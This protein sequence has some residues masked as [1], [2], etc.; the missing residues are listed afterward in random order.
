MPLMRMP[1][2]EYVDIAD[3]TPPEVLNR[4]RRQFTAKRTNTQPEA[5]P[6]VRTARQQAKDSLRPERK[7]TFGEQ[8]GGA[9]TFGLTDK[10]DAA[11]R[12]GFAM[13]K[14]GGTFSDQY[15]LGK[16]QVQSEKQAYEEANPVT[17]TVGTG[18][19]LLLNPVGAETGVGALA[20]KIAPSFMAKTAATRGGMLAS[21]L[22]NSSAGL[23]LRAGINQGVL[24]GVANSIDDPE[25]MIANIKNEAIT[26]GAFGGAGGAIFGAAGKVAH[27]LKDRGAGSA[28]RVAFSKVD[29]ALK[30]SH[31]ANG[32]P[33]TPDTLRNEIRATDK[34]GGD[35][36]VMDASPELRNMG[37]YLASRP[38]LRAANTLEERVTNRTEAM[39]DRFDVAVNRTMGGRANNPD[40]HQSVKGITAARKAQGQI[41]YAVGG[42]MDKPIHHSPELDDWLLNAPPKTDEII[43]SAYLRRLNQRE[44]PIQPSQ[45][46]TFDGIPNMRTFDYIKQEFDDRIGAA[47]KAGHTADARDMSIELKSLKDIMAKANPEYS[48]ILARQRDAFEK[49]QS[50]ELGMNFIKRMRTDSRQLLDDMRKENV[51]QEQMRLGV[52]DALLHMRQTTDNPVALMRRMMRHKDQR[53][54]LQYVFG[55]NKT[56]NEFERF[57]RREMR[58]AKT[59]RIVNPTTGSKTNVLSQQGESDEMGGSAL[60]GKSMLQGFAFGGP[61]GMASRG[62]RAIDTLSSGLGPAAQEELAKILMGKGENLK[63]GTEA[64]S[65]YMKARELRTKRRA[66]MGGKLSAGIVSGNAKE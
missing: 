33:Y 36:M 50:T 20:T 3:G 19:G 61:A 45:N 55:S 52:A 9:L 10:L 59:D 31:D 39:P 23:G 58:S 47:M 2:G 24:T 63:A 46:G 15:Q 18:A 43:R 6:P 56:L 38:G 60:L 22:G 27:V 30:R 26:Q 41:D 5:P 13:L 53:A 48:A 11:V 34:A 44:N 65:K 16:N 29:D 21:K 7:R 35:A 4:I 12:A 62:L 37:G 1:N 42:N 28:S 64:A 40:A 14:N 57:M 54:V 25:N 51:N 8:V 49:V 66:V 17:S 32:N